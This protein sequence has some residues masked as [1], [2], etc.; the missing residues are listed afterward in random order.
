MEDVLIEINRLFG[1]DVLTDRS[2]LVAYFHDLAPQLSKQRRILKYFVECNGPQKLVNV[3]EASREEQSACVKR[4]VK[5]MQDELF[6]ETSASQIVCD[7]FLYAITNQRAG[8][9][10]A[11]QPLQ[12]EAARR[13]KKE[14][15]HLTAE[16]QYQK[17]QAY[18]SG[19][20][21]VPQDY[22]KAFT[23]YQKA[24]L[25]GHPLAQCQVGLMYREG[26]G[27]AKDEKKAFD[28]FMKAAD[29][30]QNC[31]RGKFYVGRSYHYGN[32]VPVDYEKA[33]MW[34][35]KAAT[36][37]DAYAQLNLGSCFER[38]QGADQ[39]LQTAVYWYG[40][41]A[42][43]EEPL[44]QCNLGC[45]YLRGRG[46]TKDVSKAIALFK[47]AIEH[48]EP[49]GMYMLGKCYLGGEGVTKDLQQAFAW[50]KQAA[51]LG[52]DQ[53]QLTLAEG[54]Q[55]GTWGSRDLK[56]A[57]LWYEK[58]ANAGLAH[59]QL[60]VARYYETGSVVEKN[61]S[62]AA[63]EYQKAANGGSVLAMVLLS[64]YY[65]RGYIFPKDD[66]LA[67]SWLEKAVKADHQLAIR[68]YLLL[69]AAKK[70]LT[71]NNCKLL[72][73]YLGEMDTIL[74]SPMVRPVLMQHGYELAAEM[75]SY[76]STRSAG[77]KI[78][79]ILAKNGCKKAQ[80]WLDN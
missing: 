30:Q 31:P 47:K 9:A 46:V 41:A 49:Y 35:F 20:D 7:A 53:A 45:M 51:E 13:G 71:E 48:K 29:D 24:A 10:A 21:T 77:I 80:A 78:I 60:Q 79:N 23:W 68:S 32:G 38:G 61:L 58:A 25:Q 42:D 6:I 17:G 37:D 63:Q 69:L 3:M 14:P 34:Y 36:R 72:A 19:T 52:D 55:K 2:R 8:A 26:R 5:E 57:F 64:H 39:D 76:A 11:A 18:Y 44:A 27:V 16:A 73:R 59:A 22:E 1:M 15:D 62:T 74:K 56:E 40:R 67:S 70:Q 12:G 66:A 75:L 4:I 28:W 43:Q 54:Y 50:I 65:A 33:V